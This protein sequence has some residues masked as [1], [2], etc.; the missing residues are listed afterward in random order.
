V[1]V[2]WDT[3]DASTYRHSH[4]ATL[5]TTRAIQCEAVVSLTNRMPASTILPSGYHVCV[6]SFGALAHSLPDV[7][8]LEAAPSRSF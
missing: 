2:A 4:V 5:K 6:S 1:L 8:A 7:Y 3:L